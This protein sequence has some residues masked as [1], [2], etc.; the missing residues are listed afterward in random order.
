[1]AGSRR[2]RFT[3]DWSGSGAKYIYSGSDVALA[4][5]VRRM[6]SADPR[7]MKGGEAGCNLRSMVA[8]C[9]FV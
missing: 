7:T 8:L 4:S 1:M 5:P 6:A 2:S 3:R 9:W